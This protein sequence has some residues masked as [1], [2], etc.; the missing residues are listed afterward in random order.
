MGETR[1]P[2]FGTSK[3]AL[4]ERVHAQELELASQ[5]MQRDQQLLSTSLNPPT[6]ALAS[7]V[8]AS[9]G[10][11]RVSTLLAGTGISKSLLQITQ[12]APEITV[13]QLP[14]RVELLN[15]QAPSAYQVNLPSTAETVQIT[16]PHLA[17]SAPVHAALPVASAATTLP[18]AV[19]MPS[20]AFVLPLAV[21]PSFSAPQQPT[22]ML[23]T[24]YSQTPSIRQHIPIAAE[25]C[26]LHQASVGDPCRWNRAGTGVGCACGVGRTHIHHH[27]YIC[28]RHK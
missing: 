6:A 14:P 21:S 20:S 11:Q 13:R 19:L 15:H 1:R 24:G 8:L 9:S 10:G 5:R 23:W 18:S 26:V 12:P 28:R 16:S 25:Q 22:T 4:K 27:H 17:T 2:L 7:P 3:R